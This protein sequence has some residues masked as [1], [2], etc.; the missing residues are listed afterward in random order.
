MHVSWFY[1]REPGDEGQILTDEGTPAGV[2]LSELLASGPVPMRAALELV[3]AA[4]DA[5]SVADEDGAVHGDLKPGDIYVDATGA[6]SLSGYGQARRSG[7]APEASPAGTATDVYGLGIVLHAVLSGQPMGAVPRDRDRHDDTIVDRLLGIDWGELADKAWMV[8]VR[9]FLCSMLAYLPAERPTALDVANVLFHV[10]GQAGG[11]PLQAWAARAVPAAGGERAPRVAVAAPVEEDLGGPQE[12]GG[13]VAQP[14]AFKVRQAASAKGESTAFWSREKIAAMLAEDEDDEAPAPRAPAPRAPAPRVPAAGAPTAGG[15]TAGGAA[16]GG[17]AAGGAAA[18]GAATR[19]PWRPPVDEAPRN[20]APAAPPFQAAAPPPLPPPAPSSPGQARP[21]AVPQ[22]SA[23]AGGPV[24]AGPIASGPVA[25]GPVAASP[26]APGGYVPPPP[27]ATAAPKKGGGLK[28][29][30]GIVVVLALLCMGGSGISAFAWYWTHRSAGERVTAEELAHQE[31]EQA[32]PE[33]EAPA[34]PATPEPAAPAPRSSSSTR[35][36][37]STGSSSSGSST[38]SGSSTSRSSGS[39][40]GSSTSSGSTAPST[41]PSTAATEPAEGPFAVKF[42]VSQGEATVQCGDSQ[43]ATFAGTT[44]LRFQA[45]TTCRVV[46][47]SSM[48]VVQLSRNS[49]VTCA[50]AGGRVSCSGS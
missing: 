35:R 32:Q 40:S 49:T 7:R 22:Q 31:E 1:T 27:P 23:F 21:L 19:Q 11:K 50:D 48:G 5:V 14:Q 4:A 36:S 13:P 9:S 29:V 28:I 6:V 15:A 33:P 38:G 24:A 3:A 34:E 12:L 8:E 26:F 46:I 18:G 41:A 45:V 16:A 10:A 17:A 2:P 39:S 43:Q 42:V 20:A 25:S 47:G 44:Q 30:L 37:S